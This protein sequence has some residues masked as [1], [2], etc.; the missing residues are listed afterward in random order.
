MRL[1]AQVLGSGTPDAAPSLLLCTE[2]SRYLFGGGE[3]LQRLCVEH[4][5]RLSR[6][7]GIFL[8][9][10]APAGLGGL[11]GLLLTMADAGRRALDV[12]GPPGL[13]D[14]LFG[15][16]HFLMRSDVALRALQLSASASGGGALPPLAYPDLTITP[17]VLQLQQQGEEG[18]GGGGGGSACAAAEQALAALYAQREW[19][20]FRGGAQLAATV[21]RGQGPPPGSSS[22]GSGGGGS[23]EAAAPPADGGQKR[24]ASAQGGADAGGSGSG[25]SSGSAAA[26]ALALRLPAPFNP[27]ALCAWP[28]QAAEAPWVV[29]ASALQGEGGGGPAAAGAA[30]AAAALLPLPPPAPLPSRTA[31]CYICQSPTVPGKFYPERARALGV[32]PGPLYG[33]LSRGEAVTV[34]APP[35]PGGGGAA[36][37]EE[38]AVPAAPRQITVLPSQ[39]KDEDLVGQAVAIVACP[40]LAFVPALAAHPSFA[41]FRRA[42]AASTAA[43]TLCTVYHTAPAPVLAAAEYVQWMAGFGAGTQHVFLCPPPAAPL[44]AE[45]GGEAAGGE[46]AV[47]AAATAAAAAAAARARVSTHAQLQHPIHHVAQAVN[48]CKLHY[49]SPRIFALPHPL[50]D[51]IAAL[52]RLSGAGEGAAS[53]EAWPLHSLVR[54]WV[55]QGLLAPPSA[56][57]AALAAG[58]SG[59]SE[60]SGA[61]SAAL[62]QLAPLAPFTLPQSISSSSSSSGSGN[63]GAAGTPALHAP[64][65]L[66]RGFVPVSLQAAP[67]PS[68]GAL[69]VL[70]VVDS[71][72]E[73][74]A[75]GK[76]PHLSARIAQALAGAPEAAAAEAA[77]A[78]PAGPGQGAAA[79]QD[80]SL[81]LHMPAQLAL[82]FTGTG[83]AIPSKYRNVTGILCLPPPPPPLPAPAAVNPYLLHCPRASLLLDC[84]EGTLGQLY[85]ALGASATSAASDPLSSLDQALASLALLSIS[86]LHAD[87]H[88][89]AAAIV[90]ARARALAAA[91]A[92]APAAAAPCAPPPPPPPPL[93]VIGPSRLY[94]WLLEETRLDAGLAGAWV[95][96]DCESFVSVPAALVGA[97]EKW[98]AAAAA[99]AAAAAAAE[100]ALPLVAATAAAEEEEERQQEPACKTRRIE[101][102]EG[103]AVAAAA[104]AEQSC[105]ARHEGP[106]AADD[107]QQQQQQPYVRPPAAECGPPSLHPLPPSLYFPLPASASS[108]GARAPHHCQYLATPE[109]VQLALQA[110]GLTA[111]RTVR[112][113]HCH[114]AYAVRL[115]GVASASG[116]G[117]GG[118]QAQ[119]QAQPWACVFSGDTRPCEEVV[120]LC[121][122]GAALCAL[123]QSWVMGSDGAAAAAAAAAAARPASLLIH[124]ATFDDTPEGR[125]HAVEKRHATAGEALGVGRRSG[126]GFVLLTHFSARHPKVPVVASGTA[127][128]V[129]YDLCLLR[130]G[131]FGGLPA[132]LPVLHELFA[133][134]EEGGAAEGGASAAAGAAM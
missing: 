76:S 33:R 90:A 63:S 89:G 133:E 39:V 109:Q 126:A 31:A 132:L 59:S 26:L 105:A 114:R 64:P 48:L 94:L 130:G 55:R 124:E 6:V 91:R 117:G 21:R 115:E 104:D 5:A 113:R 75:Q 27:L 32:K 11:P 74:A 73:L 85:R 112:V 87:H 58:S 28:P 12:C 10:G 54:A 61:A 40:S 119:A 88:L 122:G 7:E 82:L 8:A 46:A 15:L 92:A 99:E 56:R 36:Q 78:A 93:L 120:A 34:D 68:L 9:Q 24:K 125:A 22:S 86:H 43:T 134:E 131:D 14:C 102:A 118:G 66:T 101:A 69:D 35:A 50:R 123:P 100:A 97:Q 128:F 107:M 16:R 51:T 67:Q 83:S 60:G 44:A 84:G 3:G 79:P 81:P 111:L 106:A 121:R 23:A 30:G 4:G 57:P 49:L 20:P 38:G 41:P 70:G 110:L 52:C 29:R 42:S 13:H 47:V 1:L 65:L 103:A 2:N 18:G 96:A 129:A 80:D 98:A 72:F 62:L 45:A 77:A 19:A 53:G 108:E 95:F 37:G 127:S 71:L 116:G 17:V 25:G